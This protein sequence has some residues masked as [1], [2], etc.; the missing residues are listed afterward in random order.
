MI[1][2]DKFYYTL[3]A[4]KCYNIFG[5]VFMEDKVFNFI[6]KMYT[7]LKSEIKS[8]KSGLTEEI[9]KVNISIG[10]EINPKIDALLD[11]YKQ[12]AEGQEETKEKLDKIEKHM[13]RLELSHVVM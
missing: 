4:K 7:D 3:A 2:R 9:R 8:V 10:Q 13:I 6:E 5:G 1:C 11:G 12:L